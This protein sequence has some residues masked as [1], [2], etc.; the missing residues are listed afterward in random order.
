M[1]AKLE[2]TRTPG[3]YKRGGR[4]AVIFRDG[5][6]HQRQ[7]S[8][9]TLDEARKLK[10]ARTA[11]VARGEFTT[12]ARVTLHEY[13]RAW[14]N[15]YQGTGRRGFREETRSEYRALLEKYALTYFPERLQLTALDPR[16]VADFIGWL[17]RQP[18]NRASC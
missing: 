10:A 18:T 4:Y 12:A 11:D 16:A 15:R 5:S 14:I 17:V 3:I 8:A 2:K 7:L 13:A 9:R 1:A 6:G